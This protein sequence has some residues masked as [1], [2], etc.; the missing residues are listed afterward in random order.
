MKRTFK[1]GWVILIIGL[2]ALAV[3]Y[4]N[5]GN[6]TVTIDHYRPSITHS[7]TKKLSTSKKFNKV[8]LA[9]SSANVVI[10]DGKKYQITYSGTSGHQTP[11][12]TVHN[13]VATIHQ[14]GNI[15]H[16]FN[17][18]SSYHNQDL[19]VITVP[20]NQVVAGRINL[21]NGDLNVK[22]M[23]LSNA[24]I[25]V[26]SGDVDYQQV[27]LNSGHT[28][29]Q[30][31]DFTANNVTINGHY[32]VNNQS[33]DNDVTKANVDGYDLQTESGDNELNSKD[34]DDQNIEENTT[35]VNVLRLITQSG[36]NTV[37]K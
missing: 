21:Q 11:T 13:N 2:L 14:S 32:T 33:G 31:G 25:N 28:S 36:D 9:V 26:A 16:T 20:H 7:Y 30:S 3:G 27:I 23:T 15:S 4:F 17:I 12:V 22:N 37:H 34:S 19:I 24:D 8:N 5:G 18:N 1:I 35:A 10:R 6:K 29:L